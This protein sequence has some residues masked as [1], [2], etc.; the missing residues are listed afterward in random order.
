MPKLANCT[1]DGYSR[2]CRERHLLHDVV[3]WWAR[4]KG[5][6]P[7]IV[8]ATRGQTIDWATLDRLSTALAGELVRRGFRKALSSI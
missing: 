3:A 8:N 1:L 7:V 4:R 6:T 5:D 2:E